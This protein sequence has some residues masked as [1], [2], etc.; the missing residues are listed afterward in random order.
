MSERFYATLGV[1]IEQLVSAELAALGIAVARIEPGRARFEG[2][3]DDL[4]RALIHLRCPSLVVRYIF[5]CY[6][7]LD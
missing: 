2:D 3:L 4:Y 6:I 7:S 5:F 1:G